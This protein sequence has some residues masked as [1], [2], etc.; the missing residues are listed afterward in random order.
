MVRKRPQ[1][2]HGQKELA[3]SAASSSSEQQ[4]RISLDII[5][6]RKKLLDGKQAEINVPMESQDYPSDNR[7]TEVYLENCLLEEGD[8]SYFSRK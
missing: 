7:R 2:T 3:A 1:L 4:L 8:I 5:A 6:R